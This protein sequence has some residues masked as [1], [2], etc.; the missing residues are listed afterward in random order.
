[1]KGRNQ[2]EECDEIIFTGGLRTSTRTEAVSEITVVHGVKVQR[3]GTS[4]NGVRKCIYW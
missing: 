3:K 2:R 1:M 4:W